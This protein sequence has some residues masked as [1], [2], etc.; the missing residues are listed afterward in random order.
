M[1]ESLDNVFEQVYSFPRFGQIFIEHLEYKVD[2]K[3][4]MSILICKGNKSLLR[5]YI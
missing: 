1:L 3:L 5:I 4:L 2:S